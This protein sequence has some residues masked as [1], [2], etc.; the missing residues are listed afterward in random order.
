ME[1]ICFGLQESYAKNKLKDLMK[2]YNTPFLVIKAFLPGKRSDTDLLLLILNRFGIIRLWAPQILIVGK[3]GMPL[4]TYKGMGVF[5]EKELE[6]IQ[7]IIEKDIDKERTMQEKATRQK[8]SPSKSDTSLDKVVLENLKKS[9]HYIL[10]RDMK[11]FANITDSGRVYEKKEYEKLFGGSD[12]PWKKNFSFLNGV[13]HADIDSLQI[14][15]KA[16][17]DQEHTCR[18]I[19]LGKEVPCKSLEYCFVMN[20]K[21]LPN[22]GCLDMYYIRGKIYWEPFG[23]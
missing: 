14:Y 17:R 16:H 5:K 4:N 12:I 15:K 23:W 20:D 6:E 9:M 7:N 1:I 2:K 3:D 22:K 10:N 8:S 11:A 18:Y 21:I 13:T 19:G